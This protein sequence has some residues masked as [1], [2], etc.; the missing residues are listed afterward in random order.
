[1]RSVAS[2]LLR[3]FITGTFTL[4]PF[5]VTVLVVTW[6]L[7]IADAYIGPSSYFGILISKISRPGFEVPGY[8]VGYLIVVI[9]IILLGFFVNRA[10]VSRI[11]NAIDSMFARIPL[12]GRIH[13]TVAQLVDLFGKKDQSGLD[14]FGGVGNVRIGNVKMLALLTCHEQFELEDGRNY[15]LVYIP[16]SPIPATGFN[17]LV[18]VEDFSRMEMPIDDLAKLLMS[19]GVL[20]PQVLNKNGDHGGRPFAGADFKYR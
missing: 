13:T 3:Y 15:V 2:A 4:L 7:R 12:F 5:V 14:R 6:T 16:N 11:R 8:I 1:M 18:P 9:L 20:G 17:M 19:L 10:T